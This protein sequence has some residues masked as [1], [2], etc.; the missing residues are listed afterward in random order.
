[1]APYT[2]E[3]KKRKFKK[4]THTLAVCK[5]FFR[6]GK[7]FI[8]CF[9][10][11]IIKLIEELESTII[12]S[13]ILTNGNSPTVLAITDKIKSTLNTLI[14]IATHTIGCDVLTQIKFSAPNT[15]PEK[16]SI[17]SAKNSGLKFWKTVSIKDIFSY[18]R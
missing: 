14:T 8:F 11:K 13:T 6:K 9:H 17:Y 10:K 4:I 16:E 2:T 1:M 12:K 15:A 3:P 5:I 18:I 7:I